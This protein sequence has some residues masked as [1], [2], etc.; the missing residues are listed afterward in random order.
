MF[1]TQLPPAYDSLLDFLA[2]KIAPEEIL[3]Y[4]LNNSELERAAW[5][6]EKSKVHQLTTDEAYE[7]KMMTQVD[8]LVRGL[9]TRALAALNK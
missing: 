7:L 8:L 3:A 1:A 2:E 9:R 6:S 4:E 5:L